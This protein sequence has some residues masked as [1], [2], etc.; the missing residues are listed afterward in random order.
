MKRL[1]M[2]WSA[3]A[4]GVIAMES[5][6]YHFLVGRDGKITAGVPVS[7]NA[8][9]IRGN[10]AA[11]T[12]NANTDAIGVCMDAMA[13]AVERPFSAGEYPITPIQVDVFCRLCADLCKQYDIPITRSTVLTHAEVQPTLKIP[14]RQ[15]WDI[16]WLPGMSAPRNPIVVGDILRQKII[17]WGLK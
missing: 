17:D 9:P 7:A 14:Q 6:R 5:N 4:D 2:H 8:A 12:L 3:G 16:T 11:H 10:Y 13:G 15:K 1:H